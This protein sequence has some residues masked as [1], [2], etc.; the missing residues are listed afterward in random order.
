MKN[1]IWAQQAS[2]PS[3][4]FSRYLVFLQLGPRRSLSSAYRADS[5]KAG[6]VPSSWRQAAHTWNWSDRAAAYDRDLFQKQFIEMER[7]RME[8]FNFEIKNHMA[9]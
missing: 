9:V 6:K 8:R 3:L 5:G 7:Y 4:W 1:K 2:E